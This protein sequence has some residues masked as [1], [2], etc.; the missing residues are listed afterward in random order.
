MV[1][2]KGVHFIK[3]IILTCAT[4]VNTSWVSVICDTTLKIKRSGWQGNLMSKTLLY[5]L[6]LDGLLQSAVPLGSRVSLT[7]RLAAPVSKT[8]SKPAVYPEL[9]HIFMRGGEPAAHGA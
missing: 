8:T 4:H 1:D 5:A 2:F 3:D 9:Y 7:Y 6:T